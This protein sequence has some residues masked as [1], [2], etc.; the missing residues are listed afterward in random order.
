MLVVSGKSLKLSECGCEQSAA[1]RWKGGGG[2]RLN[3]E[4]DLQ[5]L[6][7]SRCTTVLIGWDPE[8]PPP[9]IWAQRGRYWSTK[10][11]DEISLYPSGEGAEC[12]GVT[13]DLWKRG[14]TIQCTRHSLIVSLHMY[15]K[16]ATPLKWEVQLRRKLYFS[17]TLSVP[18]RDFQIFSAG[19]SKVE[20][21]E[22][23]HSWLE[24][25]MSL[26]LRIWRL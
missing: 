1:G 22:P 5:S 3:M 12:F 2:Q 23:G 14:C 18:S 7:S 4:L 25:I 6:L 16:Y 19:R 9:R 20:A 10:I 26:N 24:T 13:V 17:L 8:T 21:R 11:D 15:C